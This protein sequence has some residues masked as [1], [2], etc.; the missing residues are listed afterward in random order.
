MT[1][2]YRLC[3]LQF[4][5]LLFK[6]EKKNTHTYTPGKASPFCY[7]YARLDLHYSS[8]HF[9]FFLEKKMFFRKLSYFPILIYNLENEIENIYVV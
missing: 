7:L 2:Y 3:N 6:K 1:T 8:F 5:K 4:S 9:M